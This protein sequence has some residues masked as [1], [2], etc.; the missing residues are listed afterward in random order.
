MR[1]TVHKRR[2]PKGYVEILEN[3][4]LRLLAGLRKTCQLLNSAC[5]WPATASMV[6]DGTTDIHSLLS[7]L[8]SVDPILDDSVQSERLCDN[9]GYRPGYAQTVPGIVPPEDDDDTSGSKHTP[10]ESSQSSRQ[11]LNSTVR[12]GKVTCLDK[13]AMTGAFGNVSSYNTSSTL[14]D[15]TQGQDD[16]PSSHCR[17]SA[18]ASLYV[19]CAEDALP[20]SAVFHRRGTCSNVALSTFEN[21]EI[22]C[23]NLPTSEATSCNRIPLV[24]SRSPC[25]GCGYLADRAEMTIDHGMPGKVWPTLTLPSHCD[26]LTDGGVDMTTIYNRTGDNCFGF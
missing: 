1:T 19:G 8:D 26:L 9:C 23:L 2:Y 12:S 14:A 21:L 10:G 24:E 3:Q 18:E 7:M 4:R 22:P 5:L 20:K 25:L 6:I 11:S 13:S 17:P 16:P 15:M